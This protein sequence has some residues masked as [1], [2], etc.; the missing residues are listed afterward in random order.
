MK[1][2]PLMTIIVPDILHNMYL[3]MVKHWMD[4]VM[5]FLEQYSRIDKFNQLWAMMPPYPGF[6]QF[7]QP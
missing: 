2:I 6:I 7:L 3:G 4:W 5:S 1:C